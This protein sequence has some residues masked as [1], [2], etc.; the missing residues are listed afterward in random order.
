[1]QGGNPLDDVKKEHEPVEELSRQIDSYVKTAQNT[2]KELRTTQSTVS[3][4]IVDE[5]DRVEKSKEGQ[6][7]VLKRLKD[8]ANATTVAATRT[9]TIFDDAVKDVKEYAEDVSKET[10]DASEEAEEAVESSDDAGREALK[11][12]SKEQK[13]DQK[14]RLD[15][16]EEEMDDSIADAENEESMY[17]EEG[18]AAAAETIA[19]TKTIFKG[20][21]ETEKSVGKTEINVN[22]DLDTAQKLISKEITGAADKSLGVFQKSTYKQEQAV[23][24][25]MDQ[26]SVDYK[27]DVLAKLKEENKVFNTAFQEVAKGTSKAISASQKTMERGMKGPQQS[28]KEVATSVQTVLFQIDELTRM[29]NEISSLTTAALSST[30]DAGKG[31]LTDFRSK[32]KDAE[33]EVKADALSVKQS[34]DTGR[35][36][37]AQTMANKAVKKFEEL[38]KMRIDDMGELRQDAAGMN[39]QLRDAMDETR[40]LLNQLAGSGVS[41]GAVAASHQQVQL[42]QDEYQKVVDKMK[43][44]RAYLT[45]MAQSA[46]TAVRTETKET[47]EAAGTAINKYKAKVDIAIGKQGGAGSSSGLAQT[48][49]REIAVQTHRAIEAQVESAKVQTEELKGLKTQLVA[50]LLKDT[51]GL[52]AAMGFGDGG[53]SGQSIFSQVTADQPTEMKQ[54]AESTSNEWQQVDQKVGDLEPSME[55]AKDILGQELRIA[56]EGTQAEV[57]T[58]TGAITGDLKDEL[59][60]WT[61]KLEQTMDGTTR[62]IKEED[63]RGQSDADAAA[64]WGKSM[65]GRLHQLS[66]STSGL[67]AQL[68]RMSNASTTALF[69]IGQGV[70]SSAASRKTGLTDAKSKVENYVTKAV[71]AERDE[72]DQAA[73]STQTTLKGQVAVSRQQ[74]AS[75]MQDSSQT[76][77]QEES[78]YTQAADT[79]KN[80]LETDERMVQSSVTSARSDDAELQKDS[81]RVQ[82]LATSG[83][84]QSQ[85]TEQELRDDQDEGL[86][87]LRRDLFS[88]TSKRKTYAQEA[89]REETNSFEEQ[90]AA[91]TQKVEQAMKDYRGQAET[92]EGKVKAATYTVEAEKDAMDR[93]QKSAVDS[94]NTELRESGSKLEL[95]KREENEATSKV[96][97]DID[98]VFRQEAAAE[99]VTTNAGKALEESTEALNDEAGQTITMEGHKIEAGVKVAQ[100]VMK[101]K[102]EEVDSNLN[103]A[104]AKQRESDSR[105]ETEVNKVDSQLRAIRLYGERGINQTE[106]LLHEAS[107]VLDA[108]L[109][110]GSDNKGAL[111]SYQR[112]SGREVLLLQDSAVDAVNRQMA[113]GEEDVKKLTA[114]AARV[115][116]KKESESEEVKNLRKLT[117]AGE[118]A[119]AAAAVLVDQLAWMDSTHAKTQAWRPKVQDDFYKL[120]E[121]GGNVRAEMEEESSLQQKREQDAKTKAMADMDGLV[122][123][124]AST[125][126]IPKLEAAM[127]ENAHGVSALNGRR[128]ESVKMR[129][130]NIIQEMTDNEARHLDELSHAES[131]LTKSRGTLRSATKRV[132][133]ME[134]TLDGISRHAEE[135]AKW[136]RDQ[137]NN[138]IRNFYQGMAVGSQPTQ[139]VA[140]LQQRTEQ[141]QQKHT[142]LEERHGRVSGEIR[143]LLS[144]LTSALHP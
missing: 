65:E 76:L 139:Q 117:A 98:S 123:Q 55:R 52:E 19:E 44:Y 144:K 81:G 107:A 116:A 112:Q 49:G 110:A 45:K 48:K 36:D 25:E 97:G 24:K 132:E 9:K 4:L 140:S 130:G 88:G 142:E 62:A 106:S 33:N 115:V 143:G 61:T 105:L 91:T 72:F 78:R 15:E 128:S 17:N 68:A 114:E 100:T 35:I 43:Q 111:K 22:K 47:E 95:V 71:E 28:Y 30:S 84:A 102:V 63:E 6:D 136:T 14:A 51:V 119:Q 7:A 131:R 122:Q 87:Q 56:S 99:A 10:E 16:S 59:S 121:T 75:E 66:S 8:Q 103:L 70:N 135:V 85:S 133:N 57:Q 80:E 40:G 64:N 32:V 138:R 42:L 79:V 113:H 124:S 2:I 18:K 1:M 74:L 89:L 141:L 134:D 108:E 46:I 93:S 94:W 86:E 3:N 5:K 127:D 104:A 21:Q 126:N 53:L 83:A 125:V 50:P 41:T 69:R 96:D 37:A 92:E 26:S 137:L 54:I 29:A 27:N 67:I 77:E 31:K 73:L 60:K 101:S 118:A 13:E 58:G 12:T 23:L 120:L 39:V 11:E 82:S 38:D 109:G 34:L 129:L 20:S 90:F